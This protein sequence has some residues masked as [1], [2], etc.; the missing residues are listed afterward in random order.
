MWGTFILR[1]LTKLAIS[2]IKGCDKNY[3]KIARG[4]KLKQALIVQTTD[5]AKKSLRSQ[6]DSVTSKVFTWCI[7]DLN[8]EQ[9]KQSSVPRKKSLEM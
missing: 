2:N 1:S 3:L 4:A 7:H 8:V 5:F 9:T 6:I